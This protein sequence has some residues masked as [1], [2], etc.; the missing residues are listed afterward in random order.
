MPHRYVFILLCCISRDDWYNIRYI[1][2]YLRE[3]SVARFDKSGNAKALQSE[4][5]NKG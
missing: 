3:A 4:A 2:T 1:Y 5:S